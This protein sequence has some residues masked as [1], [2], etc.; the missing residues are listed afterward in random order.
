MAVSKRIKEIKMFDFK[1]DSYSHM[2]FVNYGVNGEIKQFCCRLVNGVWKI[3]HYE[4]QEW[5]Q[6]ATGLPDDATECAPCGEF[7]DGMWKV[8]FIAGG[9]ESG[10]EFKLYRILGIES[11]FSMEQ[12]SADVGFVWKYRVCYGGRRGNINIIEPGRKHKIIFHRVE[13]L[14]RI[15]FNPQNPNQLLISGQFFGGEIF[16]W[17]YNIATRKLQKI[18]ADGNVAYKAAMFEGNCFYASRS[19][20]DAFEE[21]HILLAQE[22]EISDICCDDFIDHVIENEDNNHNQEEFQ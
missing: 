11:G 13:Y 4:N 7:E 19:E 3:H 14:Y 18:S 15:S 10:R 5:L 17:I 22:L 9:A 20:D 8:S 6:I 1:D 16:S 12:C 2:P 21:R